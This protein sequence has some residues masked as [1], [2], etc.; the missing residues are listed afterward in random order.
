[1]SNSRRSIFCVIASLVLT[2]PTHAESHSSRIEPP[3]ALDSGQ[4]YNLYLIGKVWGYLK[5]H[6]PTITGG[7]LD[8]DEYLLRK[9]PA[10]LKATDSDQIVN[11][12]ASWI[13]DLDSR[14]ACGGESPGNQYFGPRTDWLANQKLLGT[15]LVDRFHSLATLRSSS[16]QHYVTQLPGRSNPT[17]VN[18]PD[19]SDVGELDWR[20]RLLALYRFWNI[21]EYWFP[22]RDVIDE[23]WDEV[24]ADS[25][26]YFF[27][28]G[29]QEGYLLELAR[30]VARIDDGHGNVRESIYVRPPGGRKMS[31]FAIRMVEGRPFIWRRFDLVHSSAELPGVAAEDQLRFGDVIMKVGGRP[32]EELFSTASPYI[33]ASNTVSSNRLIAQFLLHGESDSI[34][35][36]VE[37]DGKIVDVKNRRL[38]RE[39]L[40]INVQHW[41]DHDG[42][43]FQLLS[44]D[45]A[46]L[47]LSKIDASR[48]A[49]YVNTAKGTKG[50]VIDIRSYP[51][52]F[53]VFALGQHLVTERTPFVRFTRIDLSVPGAF[54]WM[55]PIAIEPVEPHY[56][57]DVVILVDEESASQS[58][59]TAMA[60]RAAPN[61]VVIGSQTAGSD[62][63]FS[64]IT[65]PGGFT[66]GM[67]GLGVFYPDKT[68]TQRV[69]IV[70]NIEVEPTIAGLRAGR[71]EVLET[72]IR[73]ILGD[74]TSDSKIREMAAFTHPVV[75]P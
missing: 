9:I 74:E 28:A 62:G 32:V 63:D 5:Y 27:S 35:L 19:Y 1:M 58:E 59:Y 33:G 75:Q 29:S 34:S 71:D 41:H 43:A 42:D 38:P 20:Y 67:S 8:W 47:K 50:L 70:P 11:E 10:M 72:A 31:P 55:E 69:G 7:C 26:P 6:H 16:G 53:V 65:L 12:L 25:I 46:Y 39:S 66:A 15:K 18:E 54:F 73:Y 48:A 37:R 60:F 44:D 4:T 52:E 24:L 45:V 51:S 49:E 21:V 23:E 57:G 36:L 61:A 30:L 64:S 17:F 68:P 3:T 2:L 13:D 22:Y 14:D 56:D 40:D